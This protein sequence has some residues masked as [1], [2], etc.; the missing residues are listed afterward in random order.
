MELLASG[1]DADVYVLDE[2]RVLRR[3]KRPDA[4]CEYEAEMQAWVQRQGFA[5][6][7]VFEASGTDMVLE[8]ISGP[9]L[10]D[11]MLAG[12]VSYDDAATM[13]ASLHA[14]LDEV[15][16]PPGAKVWPPVLADSRIGIRH[17]DLHPFNVLV[18]DH[19]PV[20]ID[21]SNTN[22]GERAVDVALSGLILAQVACFEGP[23]WAAAREL[24]I[25]YCA[26]VPTITA[27]AMAPALE[28][29]RLDPNMSDGEQAVLDDAATLVL[30]N[31]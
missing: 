6:P 14:G 26:A 3:C 20:L 2:D 21:W 10:V 5:A 17:F 30:A 29:R 18:S 9:T 1:R 16:A 11:A 15:Q 28:F 7:E 27:E 13:L 31:S 12:D 24:V 19:G 23:F 22:V 4:Q 25:A 8:R